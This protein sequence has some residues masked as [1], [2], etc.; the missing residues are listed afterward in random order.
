MRRTFIELVHIA[1][2]IVTTTVFASGAVWALPHAADTIW[3]VAYG[4]IVVVVLMGIRPLRLAWRADHDD[5]P[6]DG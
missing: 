2:G 3:A 6:A 4:V 5:R 1:A